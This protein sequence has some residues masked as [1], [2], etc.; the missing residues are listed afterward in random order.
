[1]AVLQW[2]SIMKLQQIINYANAD[3]TSFAQIFCAASA[4]NDKQ[5]GP[6]QSAWSG[7]NDPWMSSCILISMESNPPAHLVTAARSMHPPMV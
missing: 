6:H 3:V 1:M 2:S 7:V 5:R 4:P